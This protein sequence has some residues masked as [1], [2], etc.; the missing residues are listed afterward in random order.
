MGRYSTY[1]DMKN[2]GL[3]QFCTT[4]FIRGL[5]WNNSVVIIDEIQNMVFTEIN[6]VITRLGEHSR[7]LILGDIAQGDLLKR[8]QEISGMERLLDIAA[9]MDTMKLIQFTRE[10]IVR[11]RFVKE[12]II[13]SE[14]T[15]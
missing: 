1:D 15:E 6:S 8:K 12:W 14:E 2:A 3:I 5:T 7:L 4:S 9:R 10:D 11:S 13:A